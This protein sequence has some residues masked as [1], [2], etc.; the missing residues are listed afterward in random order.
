MVAIVRY[1][2]EPFSSIRKG[3]LLKVSGLNIYQGNARL[4]LDGKAHLPWIGLFQG[5]CT[6]TDSLARLMVYFKLKS[7]SRICRIHIINWNSHVSQISATISKGNIQHLCWINYHDI[8]WLAAK[9]SKLSQA[10]CWLFFV[11]ASWFLPFLCWTVDYCH[12][13]VTTHFGM[14][15]PMPTAPQPI[16][17]AT[18]Q[19]A[20][21]L[22]SLRAVDCCHFLVSPIIR[23]LL[24][25]VLAHFSFCCHLVATNLD[26]ARPM[27]TMVP[28]I[29][30]FVPAR[31]FFP[32]QLPVAFLFL[33]P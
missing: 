15:P 21:S 1:L 16:A 2:P 19:L 14:L 5:I 9:Y 7:E 30:V 29:A 17:V 20:T 8:T 22:L 10:Y 33:L 25:A 32:G 13:L 31:L 12:L 3:W 4:R 18:R 27:P 11:P 28:P 6:S 24:A 26:V 23:W